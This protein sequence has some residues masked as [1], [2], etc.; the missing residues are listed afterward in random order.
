M[1][2][3]SIFPFY[4]QEKGL[5]DNV[6]ETGSGNKILSCGTITCSLFMY[7]RQYLTAGKIIIPYHCFKK[8]KIMENFL[9]MQRKMLIQPPFQSRPL[10]GISVLPDCPGRL[11]RHFVNCFQGLV[12][13]KVWFCNNFYS[14]KIFL[15]QIVSLFNSTEIFLCPILNRIGCH[16]F[17]I[18]YCFIV[19]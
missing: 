2:R 9:P 8:S 7:L 11:K 18:L 15:L 4:T 13:L 6:I 10:D 1:R 5:R 16:E 3:Y 14:E 17:S 19:L 12:I